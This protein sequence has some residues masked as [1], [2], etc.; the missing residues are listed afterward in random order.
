MRINGKVVALTGAGSGIGRALALELAASG[1]RLALADISEVGLN[2]TRTLVESTGGVATC[3]V[4]DVACREGMHAFAADVCRE[5]GGVDMVIN[6]AGVALMESVEDVS[7]EDLQWI[8]GI[9][10]WGVVHGTKAFLPHLKQRQEAAVVNI[11]SVAGL[12]GLP[13]QA[14]YSAT[15]FAVR[16]FSEAMRL[17][18]AATSVRVVCVHAGGVKTPL[19]SNARYFK[20]P[21]RPGAPP[22]QSGAAERFQKKYALTTPE[23]AARKIVRGVATGKHRVLVGPDAQ[24]IDWLSRFFPSLYPRLI[25]FYMRR[26]GR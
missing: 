20:N 16:G 15:K 21:D 11:S 3:H 26:Q 13:L 12:A 19:V 23:H 10:F 7:Y 1:S 2:A 5:H 17:E 14:A 25:A 18:L 24:L 6:N 9:N 4:V 22:D 8:V